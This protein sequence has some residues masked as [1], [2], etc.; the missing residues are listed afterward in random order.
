MTIML[1]SFQALPISV[2]TG[3]LVH[4]YKKRKEKKRPVYC[5]ISIVWPGGSLLQ[6]TSSPLVDHSVYY[7]LFSPSSVH[8]VLF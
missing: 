4:T 1:L 2:T 8:G 5:T 6:L 7:L 3:L